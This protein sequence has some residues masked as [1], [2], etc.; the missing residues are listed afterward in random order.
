MGANNNIGVGTLL[1]E[2]RNPGLVG[3][4]EPDAGSRDRVDLVITQIIVMGWSR[5]GDED[6]T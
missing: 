1:L 4:Q 2:D 3:V 5:V 6:G